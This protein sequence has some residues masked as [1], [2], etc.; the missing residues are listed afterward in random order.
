MNI[1]FSPTLYTDTF[2][3]PSTEHGLT[4]LK[5]FGIPTSD[6]LT[7]IELRL[8]RILIIDN[9]QAYIPLIVR[10][11]DLYLLIGIVDDLG[12]EPES[13]T[14]K[15]F[16]DIDDNEEL[17]VER[18]AYYWKA[19]NDDDKAP[20]QIH[21]VTSIIKSNEGIRNTG[22][23]LKELQQSD[24]YKNVIKTVVEAVA[25]G[26]MSTINDGLIAVT[27]LLGSILGNVDDTPLITSVMSFTDIGGEFDKLGK[28]ILTR[29]NRYAQLETTLVVRDKNR[30]ALLEKLN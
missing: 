18:T 1:N 10:Y 30:E 29:K 5:S 17:P 8:T 2:L 16:A 25:T 24:D 28:H 4:K 14:I 15:G 21:L 6:Q 27:G 23:A 11:S 19:K 13:I 12:G 7:G 22:K 3:L 20:G 9:K 26:G